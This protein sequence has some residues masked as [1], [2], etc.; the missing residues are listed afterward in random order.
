VPWRFPGDLCPF[1]WNY[2]FFYT[3]FDAVFNSLGKR[4][5]VCGSK[6]SRFKRYFNF[7]LVKLV[8]WKTRKDNAVLL[9][10]CFPCLSYARFDEINIEISG[11]P[12]IFQILRNR[13]PFCREWKTACR[14]VVYGNMDLE[15]ASA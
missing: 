13:T 3:S 4:V 2:T 1:K 7:N 10:L 6:N 9:S 12:S 15:G 11:E 8:A 14:K 5:R